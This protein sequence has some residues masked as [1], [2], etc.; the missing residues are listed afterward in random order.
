MDCVQE[1]LDTEPVLDDAIVEEQNEM[2]SYDTSVSAHPCCRDLVV[3]TFQSFST[4]SIRQSLSGITSSGKSIASDSGIDDTKTDVS[5]TGSRIGISSEFQDEDDENEDDEADDTSHG[6]WKAT[7]STKKTGT[8]WDRIILASSGYR[9]PRV[10]TSNSVTTGG[11]PGF[12][13]LKAVAPSAEERQ[14]KETA[15][16]QR[17][18]E[19]EANRTRFEDDDENDDDGWEL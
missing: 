1:H 10:S 16:E 17:Y 11:N 12:V 14:A 5:D 15:N 9:V 4:Q 18:R 2:H 13:K 6:A 19:L 3:N 8:E 7:A